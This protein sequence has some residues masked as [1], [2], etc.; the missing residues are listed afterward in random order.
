MVQEVSQAA[1]AA[2]GV[3]FVVTFALWLIQGWV[4][5]W[6]EANEILKVYVQF[7]AVMGLISGLVI[8]IL[9]S[10]GVFG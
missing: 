6:R 4:S 3:W 9:G 1:L 8:L 7:W 10:V 2:L 5:G